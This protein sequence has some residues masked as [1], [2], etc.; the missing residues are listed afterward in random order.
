LNSFL[1]KESSWPVIIQ[2]N[3]LLLEITSKDSVCKGKLVRM[4]S[5]RSS[6]LFNLSIKE[7][8]NGIVDIRK[9]FSIKLNVM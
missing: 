8:L 6:L 1:N 5:E 9:I 7:V 2:A 3:L 4:I